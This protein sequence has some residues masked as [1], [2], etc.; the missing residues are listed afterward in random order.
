MEGT[1]ADYGRAVDITTRA[2][3][4]GMMAPGCWLSERR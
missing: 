1:S 2:A 4:K 3:L